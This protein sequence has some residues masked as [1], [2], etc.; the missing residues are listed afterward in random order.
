MSEAMET[1]FP[2]RDGQRR[3][4]ALPDLLGITLAGAVA[5]AAAVA[6]LDGLFALVGLGDFGRINGWLAVILPIMLL[7]EEFRAWRGVRG[8]IAVA[9]VAAAL[10][11]ATGLVVAGLVGDLP[12][13]VTGAIGAATFTVVY[14]L[15]WFFGIRAVGGRAGEDAS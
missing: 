11:V 13:L 10:A 3:I 4:V 9:L 12:D 5:A 7:V 15:L 1:G 14:S 2:R 8:R 6:L